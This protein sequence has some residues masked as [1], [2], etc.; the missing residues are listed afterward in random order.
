MGTF[1][2]P[3][4]LS[5]TATGPFVTVQAMVDT[6][7]TYSLFPRSVLEQLGV[8]PQEQAE[9]I[10]ADGRR[11]MRDLAIITVRLEGRVR[12]GVCV[13]GENGAEPL[14]GAVT[15]ESF[16]LAADPVNRRLV[17]APLYL[18]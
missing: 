2:H 14:L 10:L 8:A 15:L 6:G 12:P 17:P 13:V 11:I 1:R 3:V 4:E 16:G 5:A 18:L 7:A 9:F